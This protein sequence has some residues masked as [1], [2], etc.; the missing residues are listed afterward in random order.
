[1]RYL[2][3]ALVAVAALT[4]TG[5]NSSYVPNKYEWYTAGQVEGS[6]LGAGR[7]PLSFNAAASYC[8]HLHAQEMANRGYIYH[9]AAGFCAPGAR[10]WGENVGVGPYLAAIHRAFLSSAA[11]RYNVLCSCFR[12]IGTGV[13]YKNGTYWVSE[14][15]YG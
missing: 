3:V 11:H 12:R 10:Y 14:I 8:A 5:E 4:F 9:S 1:M 15:F 2:V 6:R 7:A 13:V